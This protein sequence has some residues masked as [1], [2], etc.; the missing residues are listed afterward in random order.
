LRHTDDGIPIIGASGR[1][2]LINATDT[3]ADTPYV[4]TA[5]VGE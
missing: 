2:P 5:D 4:L 3:V 1:N